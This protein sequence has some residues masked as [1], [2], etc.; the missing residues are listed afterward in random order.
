MNTTI[1][2]LKA[3]HGD[4]FIVEIKKSKDNHAVIVIDGGL[5]NTFNRY[6][7]P[8]INEFSAIDL[9]V[10]THTD[11]DHIKGLISFFQSDLF[12]R[13]IIDEYWANCRYSIKLASGSQATFS[14][15]KDFDTFLMQKEGEETREKWNKD[16]IYT[17]ESYNRKGIEF[18]VLSPQQEQVDTFYNKWSVEEKIL[19]ITQAASVVVDQLQ[20]GKVEDLAK[21]DFLPT[22]NIIDDYVNASSIA[23]IMKC[24]DLSIL[25]LSDARPEIIVDSLCQLG[26][27][28]SNRLKIDYVKLS[29]H[30]S[31]N[32]TSPELLNCIDCDHFIV[33]T[34]GGLGR[35]KHPDRETIARIFCRK[36]RGD[37]PTYLYF[38]YHY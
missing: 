23:F 32:N 28:K 2:F 24:E 19:A 5:P 37:N 21:E 14:S 1:H 11:D 36:N 7:K 6:F 3:D 31:K 25:F 33:S 26:Y 34:D 38:N 8:I 35:S 17:G 29:H 10:L 9:L 15:A 18:M 30:G 4:S 16:I 13:T 27:N 20:R 22:R 12:T